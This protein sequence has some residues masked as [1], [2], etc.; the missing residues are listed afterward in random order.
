MLAASPDW[1]VGVNDLDLL[2]ANGDWRNQIVVELLSYDAG[3]GDGTGFSLS[4]PAT[5]PQGTVTELDIAEPTG[6]LFGAGSLARLSLTRSVP[7]PGSTAL[8]FAFG[9]IGL[10][11]RRKG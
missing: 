3:T 8:S 4:N 1:F 5:N 6:A 9:L 11:R 2:D 7:E 10:A